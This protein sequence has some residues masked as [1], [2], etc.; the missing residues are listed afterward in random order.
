VLLVLLLLLVLT[1]LRSSAPGFSTSQQLGGHRKHCKLKQQRALDDVAGEGTL[2]CCGPHVAIS[3]VMIRSSHS[4][5]WTTSQAQ[6]PAASPAS[7]AAP[8]H[9]SARHR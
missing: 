6:Q 5:H 4:V 1:L 7:A 9:R 8:K 3:P 2:I